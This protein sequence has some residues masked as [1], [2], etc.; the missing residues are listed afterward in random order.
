MPFSASQNF[1]MEWNKLASSRIKAIDNS[2]K[3]PFEIRNIDKHSQLCKKYRWHTIGVIAYARS[4]NTTFV[5][6][7]PYSC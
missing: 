7:S 6:M 1:E 3:L 5:S 4:P 2:T